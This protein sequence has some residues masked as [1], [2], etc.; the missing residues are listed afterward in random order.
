MSPRTGNKEGVKDSVWLIF[1]LI[2]SL[3]V[4][5][6]TV[7]ESTV[8]GQI[9]QV[10][11]TFSLILFILS[12]VTENYAEFVNLN[13]ENIGAQLLI[14]FGLGFALVGSLFGFTLFFQPLSTPYGI[15]S[16]G[17]LGF[18][19]LTQ[20]FLMS[21]VVAEIEETFRTSALRPTMA[22]WMEE[23]H[24][25]SIFLTVTATILWMVI[26]SLRWLGVAV[27]G[28]AV[29]TYLFN[30]DLSKHLG[31]SFVRHGLAIL[32]AAAFFAVLHLR[33]YG[34]SEYAQVSNSANLLKNAFFFAIIA[35]VINTKFK[36]ATP[37]K[38]AH[39][40]NNSTVSSVNAG[41]PPYIG[42]VVTGVYAII[43]FMMSKGKLEDLN[44][45][46]ILEGIAG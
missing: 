5:W 27:F 14:G 21:V 7:V 28:F 16:L 12:K 34:G 18:E 22:E 42:F 9:Y 4:L 23:R 40:M 43:L 11:F 19:A 2:L 8:F 37:S 1:Y 30:I 26:P 38:V 46:K 13:H 6:S 32:V 44:P 29:F 35:D 20:V 17:L 45:T 41:L 15:K 39:C 10:I 33:A 24:A 3:L 31:S 25:R 36:A